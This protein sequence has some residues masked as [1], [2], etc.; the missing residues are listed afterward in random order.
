MVID[1][2]NLV[3][4]SLP[5]DKTDPPLVA[6]PDA[7]LPLAIAMK[8]F[9]PI[10]GRRREVARFGRCIQL[11]KFAQRHS[12]DGPKTPHPV[13]VVEALRIFAAEAPNHPM[14]V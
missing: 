14:S 5:P 12:F 9:E 13:P 7:V 2:L 6:N 3:S 1:D 4:V 10:A 11:A 8:R